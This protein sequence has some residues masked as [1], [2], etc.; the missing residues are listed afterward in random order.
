MTAGGTALVGS[1]LLIVAATHTGSPM[2]LAQSGLLLAG[3]GMGLNTGPLFGIAVGAVAS[4]RSGTASALI[5]VARMT[6]ATLGVALL[7]AVSALF[8]D[9][10]PGLSAAL[11]IGGLVQLGGALA[12][13]ATV[14]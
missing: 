3:L 11:T 13:F 9:G 12:A 8:H 5:N 2:W 7:G 4:E 1:G 14:R 6:G 10:A